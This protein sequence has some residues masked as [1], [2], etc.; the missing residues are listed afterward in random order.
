MPPSDPAESTGPGRPSKVR[1]LMEKYDL[2]TLGADLESRWTAPEDERDSLRDLATYANQQALRHAMTEA[3][4][5]PLEGEV[6]NTYR[7]LTSDDVG[8]GARTQAERRLK[9]D[10][11]DVDELRDDFVSYQAV[12]T[13]LRNYREVEHATATEQQDQLKAQ[14]AAFQRIVGRTETM[15]RTNLER[16]QET[17]QLTL[18]E[19]TVA[20]P[21]RVI[22]TECET[23]FEISKLLDKGSCE[24]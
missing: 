22:C 1:Q 15:A 23:R 17:G 8:Q 18:G 12:R 5:T 13:Y 19:F 24:C 20:A 16:L 10:G 21:I 4:L 9:R 2:P 3:G 14:A 11:I 6:G 7:L